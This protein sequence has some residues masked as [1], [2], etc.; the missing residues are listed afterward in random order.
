MINKL[1][2]VRVT[3]AG[4]MAE[5]HCTNTNGSLFGGQILAQSLVAVG[6]AIDMKDRSLH[7]LHAYF[8]SRG[9]AFSPVEYTVNKVRE[10][11]SFTA[12][13]VVA[14]QKGKD[15]FTVSMSFQ[16]Q[17]DAGVNHVSSSANVSVPNDDDVSQLSATVKVAESNPEY[18][19]FSSHHDEFFDIVTTQEQPTM[20]YQDGRANSEFWIRAG[21]ELISDERIM[22]QACLLAASDMGVLFS[23]IA[24]YKVDFK[25]TQIT[26]ID[27]SV[28]LHEPHI[29]MNHW[30]LIRAHSCWAGNS[31]SLVR[32]DIFDQ[33]G[34]LVA[35][36]AQE[37]LVRTQLLS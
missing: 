23:T 4:L 1:L 12:V 30:H 21:D 34:T 2:E 36:I 26:S 33:T 18:A 8:I 27:H 22:H 9:D 15:I 28:W 17:E 25:K 32:A 29:D 31:R 13:S 14:S 19:F 10:G 37:G 20:L 6:R 16:R 11:R 7:S 24:P 5:N 3:D 35:T